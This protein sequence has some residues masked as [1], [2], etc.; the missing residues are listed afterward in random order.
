MHES[1]RGHRWDAENGAHEPA[2]G[3][4]AWLAAQCR[5]RVAAEEPAHLELLRLVMFLAES[6][7][8]LWGCFWPASQSVPLSPAAPPE[9]QTARSGP[10]KIHTILGLFGVGHCRFRHSLSLD[11][12][13]QGLSALLALQG[14]APADP[15]PMSLHTRRLFPPPCSLSLLFFHQPVDMVLSPVLAG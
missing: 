15:L 14:A 7:G 6:I 5:V 12:K 11:R 9:A 10:L 2:P 3:P 4:P 13:S 1:L 8:G